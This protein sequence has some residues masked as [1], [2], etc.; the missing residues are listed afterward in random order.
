MDPDATL[1]DLLWA[2]REYSLG[3]V[4]V[5]F[6]LVCEQIEMLDCW[7]TKGGCL[8]ERWQKCK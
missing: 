5:D 2:S 3:N 7:I 4:D 1:A 6:D 8:P